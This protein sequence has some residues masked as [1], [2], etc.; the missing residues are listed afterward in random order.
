MSSPK[1]QKLVDEATLNALCDDC[2]SFFNLIRQYETWELEHE[3]E[4]PLQNRHFTM[5]EAV[6]FFCDPLQCPPSFAQHLCST[7]FN[8]VV[9]LLSDSRPTY[10]PALFCIIIRTWAYDNHSSLNIASS[11]SE[12]LRRRLIGVHEQFRTLVWQGRSLRDLNW[13]FVTEMYTLYWL[14]PP[15]WRKNFFRTRLRSFHQIKGF[16]FDPEPIILLL[17][18]GDNLAF[19]FWALLKRKS[20]DNDLVRQELKRLIPNDQQMEL[21]YASIPRQE[22]EPQSPLISLIAKTSQEFCENY[23]IPDFG[24]WP[25]DLLWMEHFTWLRNYIACTLA[26]D[27]PIWES[28]FYVLGEKHRLDHD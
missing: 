20:R 22:S 5:D 28:L 8:D 3:E 14:T 17:Q 25:S 12:P 11:V 21:V 19:Y 13:Q 27:V 10:F 6:A 15:E 23:R 2:D 24:E 4:W 26:C 18:P 16:D 9:S 1:R 7:Y